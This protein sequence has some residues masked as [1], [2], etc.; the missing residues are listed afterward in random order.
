MIFI[1]VKISQWNKATAVWE[2]GLVSTSDFSPDCK[3]KRTFSLILLFSNRTTLTQTWL[4]KIT[5]FW[6]IFKIGG[7]KCVDEGLKYV[8]NHHILVH[9]HIIAEMRGFF[10]AATPTLYFNRVF[11]VSPTI[12]LLATRWR[13]STAVRNMAHQLKHTKKTLADRISKCNFR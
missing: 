9:N 6:C 10:G 4:K 13:S 11:S 5:L 2:W 8:K 12:T 1:W 7:K 3:T